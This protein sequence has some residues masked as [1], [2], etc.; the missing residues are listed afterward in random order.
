MTRLRLRTPSRLH[1]GLLGWG[2]QAARQFGG[3]GL[4]IEEPG[5]ELIAEPAPDWSVDGPLAPRV[6]Q[7]APALVEE[8]PERPD[9]TSSCPPA[10]H[11]GRSAPPDHVGLGVGTQLSLAVVRCSWSSPATASHRPKPSPGSR[12]A[13]AAPGS[14]STA[15]STE[16][17]IVDGGRAR[18]RRIPLPCWLGVEFP[19]DW[20]ILIVQPP[21]RAA[22][23]EP[24]RSG[25]SP[26]SP[27]CPI[28]SPNGSA[29]WSCSE[30]CPAVVEKRPRSLRRSVESNCRSTSARP[31]PPC[32][33]AS[34]PPR[35]PRR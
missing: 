2:P 34:T 12:G 20:S 3:V 4:M 5:L 27:R 19:E 35:S 1:F 25:P 13:A 26:P 24:M 32:R 9:R 23:M 28:G 14:G 16:G 30:S 18:R 29:A 31:L 8:E 21:A 15:S 7:I 11:P 22:A 6:E 17:L 33:E 10:Q